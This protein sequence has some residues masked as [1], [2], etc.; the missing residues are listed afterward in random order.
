MGICNIKRGRNFGVAVATKL[1]LSNFGSDANA[2]VAG[3]IDAISC[4]LAQLHSGGYL[5]VNDRSFST[6]TKDFSGVLLNPANVVVAGIVETMIAVD[7][8]T[9]GFSLLFDPS[10]VVRKPRLTEWG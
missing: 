8:A 9:L 1:T 4:I 5:S 10:T 2:I 6:W 7:K 3:C